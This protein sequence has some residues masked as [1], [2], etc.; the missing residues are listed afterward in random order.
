MSIK[1]CLGHL[2]D[3]LYLIPHT[4]MVLTNNQVIAF[5]TDPAQMAL[6]DRTRQ[7]FQEEGI[8]TPEDLADYSSDAMWKQLLSNAKSP[9][10]VPDPNNPQVM[11]P[12]RPYKI[13]STSLARLKVAAKAVKFWE[14][15]SRALTAA[16]LTWDPRLKSFRDQWTALSEMKEKDD[17]EMPKIGQKLHIAK[18]IESFEV[19]A[20]TKIGV[21]NAPLAYVIR[22]EADVPAAAPPLA[23]NAPHSEQ[24][25]SVRGELIA[26]LS[27]AHALFRDDNATVFDM[28]ETATRGTKYH[29]SI[30]T[31]KDTQNG[32]GAWQKLKGQYAGKALFE[33]EQKDH[34]DTLLSSTYTGTGNQ[35]L[36]QFANKHRTAYAGLVR[37]A[38][39]IQTQVPD[40]HTRVTYFTQNVKSQDASI[41]AAL[42][43]IKLDDGPTGMRNNFENMVTH[44]VSACP[45][46]KKKRDGNKRSF[47]EV[48]EV[49]GAVSSS[50]GMKPA[51]GE[52]GVEFR[53]Y[54]HDEYHKLTKE[55]QAELLQYRKENNITKPKDGNGSRKSAKTSAGGGPSGGSKKKL[56][57]QVASVLQSLESKKAKKEEARN[58]GIA[59]I[60]SF[61]GAIASA[62]GV[63][64]NPALKAAVGSADAADAKSKSLTKGVTFAPDVPG[65][66][67]AAANL[68]DQFTKLAVGGKK[69]GKKGKD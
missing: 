61:L 9:G 60:Q 49:D 54:K 52:T 28:I 20:T 38:E 58:E 50:G 69:K 43:T 13:G 45:V 14:D 44:I 33:K 15:T 39:H 3:A 42:E 22:P 65:A 2:Y 56:R 46:A 21:R 26:R 12:D 24:H 67:V 16:M 17:K 48:A 29:T 68:Y 34:M 51:R 6:S 1:F 35:T 19:F 27:H 30:I 47:A 53:Y 10:D 55:Q 40:E 57:S 37:C 8:N 66:E 31:F 11:I 4:T 36:D 59:Q 25:G 32:R 18:W 63:Q 5:F 23:P 7:F 62:A 64:G 41:R